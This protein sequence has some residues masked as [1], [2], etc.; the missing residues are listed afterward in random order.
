MKLKT[1]PEYRPSRLKWVGKI[2]SHW[3][4]KRAKYYFREV[5]ERSATGDEELLSVSHVTGV[6]PRTQKNVT[7]FKAESY[8]GHKVCRPGD[9]VINTM[10]AW[11]AAMGIAKQAGITSPSY[12][13][14]RLLRLSDYVPEYADHLLRTKAYASEYFCRSTGIRSSRLRLYPDD[15]LDIPIVCPPR[16]EQK[17]MLAYLKTKILEIH[18]FIRNKERLIE[19]LQEQKQAIINRAVTRGIDPD[20]RL[21]PSGIDWLGDVPE[22]WEVRKTPWLF[23]T[24]GSGTTP[25]SGNAEFYGGNINWAMTGDLNDGI[26]R[27]TSRTVTDVALARYS[28]LKVYPK[29]S[30]IVA[31]YGATIG[32]TSITDIEMCTN[33]ACC[34]LSKPAA[35]IDT[36]FVMNFLIAVRSE[37]VRMSYGGGQPNISQDIIRS[38]RIPVPPIDEQMDIV[39]LIQDEAEEIDT[40]ITHTRR[41]I[42]LIREYRTRLIADVVTG[43]VDVRGIPV[44]AVPEGEA[45]EEFAKS[46][47]MEEALDTGEIQDA[48]Q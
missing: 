8:I 31:M 39:L 34:V 14:Y 7:M 9:L 48:K 32:K 28:T 17:A 3:G 25:E 36:L 19:L 10:W 30:L 45:P 35:F 11:M 37:L 15:F 13:V 46:R 20:V 27:K 42:D 44:E 23:S 40:A 33:Q 47:E 38:L 21:K 6:T 43:K 22:H 26:L 4:E 1:Y 29:G 18:R 2:P 16:D 41:Q 24:I 5:D 12:G